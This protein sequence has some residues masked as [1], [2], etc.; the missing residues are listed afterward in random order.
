MGAGRGA[1]ACTALTVVRAAAA[2]SKPA[3][4][5]SIVISRDFWAARADSPPAAFTG[6]LRPV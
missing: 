4:F 2:P 3:T 6:K 1:A 5:L